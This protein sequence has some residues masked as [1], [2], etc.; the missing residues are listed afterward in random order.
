MLASSLAHQLG[1][2]LRSRN[3]HGCRVEADLPRM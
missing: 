1:G 2:K 3:D